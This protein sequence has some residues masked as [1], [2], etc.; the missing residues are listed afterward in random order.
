MSDPFK[1][2]LDEALEKITDTLEKAK[3][4]LELSSNIDDLLVEQEFPVV[5]SVLNIALA[6]VIIDESE[7]YGDASAFAA[8]VLHTLVDVI[9]KH[10]EKY[11][12]DD[13]EGDEEDGNV[14]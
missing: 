2:M 10:K 9:D 7:S 5:M 3:S 8:R 11:P 14:H 6:K 13:E 12:S 4:V 1:T